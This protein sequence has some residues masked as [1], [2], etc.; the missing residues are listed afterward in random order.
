VI[1]AGF[2]VHG[3]SERN[4]RQQRQF[5]EPFYR[6]RIDQQMTGKEIAARRCPVPTEPPPALRLLSGRNPET[7]GITG[8]RLFESE[9]VGRPDRIV[10][11]KTKTRRGGR[12]ASGFL[13]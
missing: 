10:M 2:Q 6:N 9:R 7:A 13:G 5:A 11:L 4:G 3:F 12:R 1:C 8:A